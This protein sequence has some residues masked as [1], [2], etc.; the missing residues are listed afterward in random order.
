MQ[1]QLDY[2]SL[3][4]WLL[5][6]R[7]YVL[8]GIALYNIQYIHTSNLFILDVPLKQG[9]LGKNGR[10]GSQVIVHGIYNFMLHHVIMT[11]ANHRL[12]PFPARIGN[13]HTRKTSD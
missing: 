4:Y 3:T 5:N 2:G 11:S 8:T 13:L 7:L 10:Q 6:R 12:N 9:I 1:S